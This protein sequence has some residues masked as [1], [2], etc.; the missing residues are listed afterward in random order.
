MTWFTAILLSLLYMFA[1]LSTEAQ[2][3]DP[4]RKYAQCMSLAETRP[5]EAREM[6]GQ[7]IGLAGG[8]PARHCQAVAMIELGEY[9]DAAK[10]LEAL[11]EGSRSALEVRAAMLAQAA[12]RGCCTVTCNALMRCRR[13]RW[14]WFPPIP[15]CSLTAP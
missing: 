1:P 9:A 15:R 7:W 6:A 12:Q 10:R 5:K 3:I 2:E 13:R 14:N 11:A 4:A 8:E